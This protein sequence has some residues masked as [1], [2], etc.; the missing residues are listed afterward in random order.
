MS[1]LILLLASPA[2][3]DLI[4][5]PPCSNLHIKITMSTNNSQA[6][7]ELIK[8]LLSQQ[9]QQQGQQQQLL[10]HQPSA[11]TLS[12]QPQPEMPPPAQAQTSS[13]S[14]LNQLMGFLQT[15]GSNTAPARTAPKPSP[16]DIHAQLQRYLQGG[17]QNQADIDAVA[18]V[19]SPAF[20]NNVTAGALGGNNQ[21]W[22][23]SQ[24]PR[25]RQQQQVQQPQQPQVQQQSIQPLL[26]ALGQQNVNIGVQQH[27][28]QQEANLLSNIK[29]LAKI[30]P[31]MAAA[32]LS[33]AL[34][35]PTPAQGP[36]EQQQ[37]QPQNQAHQTRQPLDLQ[38][39]QH[40]A[41]QILSAQAP[42]PFVTSH[43]LQNHHPA[44]ATFCSPSLNQGLTSSEGIMASL[45]PKPSDV[46]QKQGLKTA[47][48]T[49]KLEQ[50]EAD[51]LAEKHQEA[52]VDQKRP[53]KKD[54]KDK[55]TKKLSGSA[56]NIHKG[57]ANTGSKPALSTA[58]IPL[59]AATAVPPSIPNTP[60][61][62]VLQHWNLEK[63]GKYTHMSKY[64]DWFII[65]QMLHC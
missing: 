58:A 63:L 34:N 7:S 40:Q 33:Q 50:G 52:K 64:H 24:P 55:S 11:P 56:K 28:Q 6:V 48:R 30:D 45:N 8:L 26:Q 57:S 15:S 2:S 61:E 37:M 35:M 60:E 27:L 31:G 62:S 42:S 10:H 65:L 46:N 53:A 25:A 39:I 38:P 49:K 5:L 19:S 29:L 12:Y 4:I 47:G 21:N 22:Y 54:S 36:R 9:Q 14:S 16:D 13:I 41:Q 3:T 51:I 23:L 44:A 32:A 20:Q 17:N 1:F 43:Q 59:P 18:Q